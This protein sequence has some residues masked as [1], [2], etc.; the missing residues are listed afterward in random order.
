MKPN[1]GHG[2]Y[3]RLWSI[4][5][6]SHGDKAAMK[7]KNGVYERAIV[8]S[9]SETRGTQRP[10]HSIHEAVARPYTTADHEPSNTGAEQH[11]WY[12][13]DGDSLYSIQEDDFFVTVRIQTEIIA[14]AFLFLS[15]SARSVL[16]FA[17][18]SKS[19]THGDDDVAASDLLRVITIPTE[20]DPEQ[21]E[22]S[23]LREQLVL[24]LP[25]ASPHRSLNVS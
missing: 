20:I 24:M 22:V 1:A 17:A 3:Q 10:E 8:R 13:A 9:S 16:L 6:N 21:A 2:F 4:S 5:D 15:I 11:H 23:F 19:E 25:V 12:G 7:R 14:G 18:P